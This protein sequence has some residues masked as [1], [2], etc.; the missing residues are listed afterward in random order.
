MSWRTIFG[1]FLWS[2]T[3]IIGTKF[4]YDIRVFLDI[5]M[6]GKNDYK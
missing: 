3:P 1:H 4:R 5:G 2:F 6:G